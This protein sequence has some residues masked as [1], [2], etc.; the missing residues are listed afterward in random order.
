MNAKYKT[1]IMK[2]SHDSALVVQARFNF[3][4]LCG[5]HILLG[6]SCLLRLLEAM[7]VLIKFV[8]GRD[9]FICD[10]V[11]T[12]KI[13]QTNIYMMYSNPSNNYLGEH[14]KVILDVV[15]NSFATITQDQVT[16]F[17]NGMETLT[18]RMV[19]HNYAVHIF[20]PLIG[21]K[22]LVCKTIFETC[23]MQVK[24]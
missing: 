16:D 2:M 18:F 21:V 4:L 13:H 11:V 14:F 5:L 8:Q 22:Q 17:N 10:F 1:M 12:I 3:N 6:L 15:E 7:N 24:V 9:V 20:N 23:I 19:G